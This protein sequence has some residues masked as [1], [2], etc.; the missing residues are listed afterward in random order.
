[1]KRDPIH[2]GALVTFKR[3]TFS[4]KGFDPLIVLEQA[5]AIVIAK[6][7]GRITIL[8]DDGKI[9]VIYSWEW[10]RVD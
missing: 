2:V 5:L 7:D 6:S 4:S 9:Y 1:M 3:A 8:S 10:K